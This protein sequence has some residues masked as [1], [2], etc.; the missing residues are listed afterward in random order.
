[1]VLMCSILEATGQFNSK[2]HS[3]SL[4][5]KTTLGTVSAQIPQETEAKQKPIC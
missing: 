1:M 5:S 3:E 4:L 2:I